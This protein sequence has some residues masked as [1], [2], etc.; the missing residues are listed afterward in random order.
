[1]TKFWQ[2]FFSKYGPEHAVTEDDLFK[3]VGH[4]WEK[5]PIGQD[6]F[7]RL[8][9]HI[10]ALLELS[11]EQHLVDFCC[12]NGLFSYELAKRVAHVT[13]ID[14][15]ERNIRIAEE[16]KLGPN[17]T[18]VVGDVTA[19]LALLIGANTFPGK[20]LMNYSLAYFGPKELDII[21]SNILQHMAD[22]PF[23]FLIAGIPCFDLKWNFYNT[24]E[25]VARHLVN[26]KKQTN[27]ND[28]LGRWWRPDEIKDIC[29][30]HRLQ[31]QV[32][33]Q[34]LDLS[35]FRMDALIKSSS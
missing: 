29:S 20:Y 33:N 4:T 25:R 7:Q 32:T 2:T 11:Q 21:L 28:G 30:R 5:R 19:P 16:R 31:V 8:V 13:G 34:P 17:T 9:A 18:Y 1:M 26:E 27:T 3:Q 23:S 12:G 15:V 22:R 10:E 24:P 35:N 6:K 14:F